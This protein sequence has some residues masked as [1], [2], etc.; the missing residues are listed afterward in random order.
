MCL[1]AYTLKRRGQRSTARLRRTPYLLRGGQDLVQIFRAKT[2]IVRDFSVLA[3]E[4]ELGFPCGVVAN[5]SLRCIYR[6][7][8][9]S[10]HS[11]GWV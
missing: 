8:L 5:E 3:Q 1:D 11:E 9:D 2:V 10:H 4:I 7:M 6:S